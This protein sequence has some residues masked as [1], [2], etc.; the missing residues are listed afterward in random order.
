MYANT[1]EGYGYP[2]ETTK[3]NAIAFEENGQ[4]VPEPKGSVHYPMLQDVQIQ[5]FSREASYR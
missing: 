5:W 3:S 1:S 4:L 2:Y